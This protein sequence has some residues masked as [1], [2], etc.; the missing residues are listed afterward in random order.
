M[1]LEKRASGLSLT[2]REALRLPR[3][4]IQLVDLIEGLPGLA[5]AL[6]YHLFSVR[7][8]IPLAGTTP[9]E[10]EPPRAGEE[11]FLGIDTL[12]GEGKRAQQQNRGES[13]PFHA[14]HCKMPEANGLQK[15][16]RVPHGPRA[17]PSAGARPRGSGPSPG[18]G[19]DPA[20]GAP[21]R[22]GGA[23]LR[24]GERIPLP[25]GRES[26]RNSRACPL[27]LPRFPRAG[28]EDRPDQRRSREALEGSL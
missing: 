18:D 9:F 5:L 17:P 15:F 22:G 23:S 12:F 10:G 28:E 3:R 25:G 20:A 19:G 21:R 7:R 16:E 13:G 27:P 1:S 6:K 11:V 4:E 24:E 8:E 26:L 14:R 2:R